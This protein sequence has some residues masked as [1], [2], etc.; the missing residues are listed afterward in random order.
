MRRDCEE[1]GAEG[2]ALSYALERGEVGVDELSVGAAAE[3]WRT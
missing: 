1:E 2:V 3:D